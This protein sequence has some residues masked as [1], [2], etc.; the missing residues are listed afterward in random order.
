MRAIIN[1]LVDEGRRVIVF[2]TSLIEI[3]IINANTNGPLLLSDKKNLRNP[4]RQGDRIDEAI[5][6]YFFNLCL[7]RFGFLEMN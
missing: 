7:Y 4:F 3:S 5:F 2:Q 6:Q 1:N